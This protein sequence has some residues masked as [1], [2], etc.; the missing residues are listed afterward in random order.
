MLQSFYAFMYLTIVLSMDFAGYCQGQ[1][2]AGSKSRWAWNK[3]AG[4]SYQI[5]F[6]V[7]ISFQFPM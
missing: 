3:R 1:R 7:M 2:Q 4:K 5:L 6:K